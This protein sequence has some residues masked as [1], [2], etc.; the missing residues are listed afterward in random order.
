MT[1]EHFHSDAGFDIDVL[2]RGAGFIVLAP[3]LARGLGYRDARDM[4]RYLG[5]DERGY[6]SVPTPGGTQTV[7]Y[8]TEP[9]FYRVL[10]QRQVS[11]IKDPLVRDRVSGF[12]RWVFHE[13]LPAL[14]THG[15]Y[16]PPAP[17]GLGA[18]V[19]LTWETAAAHLRQH[20][21]LPID[22]PLELRQRLTDA[23]V[24]K[25]TGTPRAGFKQLFWAVGSR[26]DI[27]AHA[28]PILA[29]RVS[30]ELYRLAEAQPGVQTA[31]E[32]DAIVQS[33]LRGDVR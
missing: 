10:G 27:H 17:G 5:E 25:L 21:G 8:V 26:Y 19:V 14:R 22:G 32:L 4:V 9:G 30:R 3:D 23:G 24:L 12:Q 11:R 15:R 1:A 20:W 7:W 18:P 2:P 28:L 29:G 16:E 6:A 13:V 33:A 31:L